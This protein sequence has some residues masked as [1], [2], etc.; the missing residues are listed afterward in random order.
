[1]NASRIALFTVV[2]GS[3]APNLGMVTPPI[4]FPVSKC[5]SCNAQMS[6]GHSHCVAVQREWDVKYLEEMFNVVQ[7]TQLL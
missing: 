2:K 5:A 7:Y 6:S 4:V 1:M 3:L